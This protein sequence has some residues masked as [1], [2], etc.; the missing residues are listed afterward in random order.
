MTNV[1]Q[2]N[3]CIYISWRWPFILSQRVENTRSRLW[4]PEAGPQ[5]LGSARW[6]HPHLCVVLVLTDPRPAPLTECGWP[7]SCCCL[8]VSAEALKSTFIAANSG[9]E[10]KEFMKLPGKSFCGIQK[11]FSGFILMFKGKA[12]ETQIFIGIEQFCSVSSPPFHISYLERK[13]AGA[14]NPMLSHLWKVYMWG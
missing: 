4:E 8:F 6:K 3:A 14:F 11:Q 1:F 7:P 12:E 5:P 10:T 13:A 2:V 9:A